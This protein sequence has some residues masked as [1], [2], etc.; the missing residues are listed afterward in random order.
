[1]RLYRVFPFD[2]GAA[3]TDLGGA[4]FVPP[5]SGLGRIDNPDLYNV[6]YVSSSAH[7]AVAE[8]FGRLA[9]WRPETFVH[10]SG[11][12][13]ALATYAAPDK[14]SY[15]DLNDVDA[16]KSIG[17]M[18]PTDVV[19]RNRETTQAWARTIFS[20]GRYDGAAW[21]SFYDPEWP[22]LGLW[23]RSAL[24]LD[25]TPEI[26]GSSSTVVLEAAAAIVRQIA[27]G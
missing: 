13:Y 17:V 10:G 23:E 9:V 27:P 8:S 26:I 20:L 25:G 1:V 14:L 16:L 4:L 18:R 19:T 2:A 7:A 15:F 24:R 11:L 5:P 6:L 22:V 21:W 3:P 12:P